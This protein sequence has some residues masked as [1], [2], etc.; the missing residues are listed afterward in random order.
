MYDSG[1]GWVGITADPMPIGLY[2]YL[3]DVYRILRKPPNKSELV[4]PNRDEK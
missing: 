4:F 2:I 3:T 1:S